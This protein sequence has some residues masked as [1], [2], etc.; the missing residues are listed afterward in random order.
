ML[1]MGILNVTPDSFSDGGRWFSTRAAI[2]HGEQLFD[3]GADIIDVGGES[4]SP[5]SEPV[6]PEEELRRVLPVITELARLGRVS[7]DTRHAEVA[8]RAVEAG[9]LMI[10]D[11][12]ASLFEIA[13]AAEVEYVAMHMQ[14]EPRTMQNAPRY[15]DVV[16]EVY[17]F[18]RIVAE[19][20]I[21]A[22]VKKCWVDPGIGFGKT[23]EHNI[24]LITN[25]PKL[26]ATGFPVAIGV[27]RK[28]MIG[29]I[30][31]RQDPVDRI[32]RLARGRICAGRPRRG[33]GEGARCGGH[34]GR[35]RG[36]QC[37][38]RSSRP[39][40]PPGLTSRGWAHRRAGR[41]TKRSRQ[42]HDQRPP[43]ALESRPDRGPR[44]PPGAASGGGSG[45]ISVN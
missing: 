33:Y 2:A 20:A 36:P 39:P 4:T 23:F 3:E 31:H 34:P 21:A 40:G 37:T 45:S 26:R 24:A 29:H 28:G 15:D 5:G 7:V 10:N 12:S 8:E 35:A 30:T 44:R 14:G 16:A 22:G 42:R 9:A 43:R 6:P 19:S 38:A 25:L 32:A 1:V 41:T 27:S 11:V 13:G 17:S 18:L